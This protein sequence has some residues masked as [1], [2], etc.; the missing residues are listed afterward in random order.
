METLTGILFYYP[1]SPNSNKYFPPI[2]D[3]KFPPTELRDLEIKFNKLISVYARAY[4]SNTAKSSC[5][6]WELG[7]KLEDGLAL[8]VLIKNSVE[9]EKEVESG[10]WETSNL[11]TI[12]FSTQNGQ[13]NADYKLTTTLVLNLNFKNNICG[14]VTLSGS[15]TKQINQSGL[16]KK[17][18]DDTHLETVGNMIEDME[19]N[20][21]N[22][23][24]EVYV[25]KSKEVRYK[26]IFKSDNRYCEI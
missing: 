26:F 22:I 13:L 1:R 16:V 25:K 21:R 20:I 5:Y 24:E 19:N 7:D 9:L 4:Y 6:A 3:G 11:V 2:T 15:L 17:Y 23:I 10:V 14:K 12:N 8:A 18:L